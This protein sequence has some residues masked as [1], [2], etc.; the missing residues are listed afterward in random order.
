MRPSAIEI[1]TMSTE[2][3]IRMS[4]I[5]LPNAEA[6]RKEIFKREAS[7][8]D[9][10]LKEIFSNGVRVKP[11]PG[12]NDRVIADSDSEKHRGD[13]DIQPFLASL[14]TDY[15]RV[16]QAIRSSEWDCV[17]PDGKMTSPQMEVQDFLASLQWRQQPWNTLHEKAQGKLNAIIDSYGR[18][19]RKRNPMGG[20]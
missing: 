2:K 15:L 1:R 13:P 11:D 20:I 17:D 16:V 8:N 19:W 14:E 4:L 10:L 18:W 3:L 12:E 9:S 6:Y 7:G 5:D